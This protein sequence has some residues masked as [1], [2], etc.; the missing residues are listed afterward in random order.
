ME[1]S[2]WQNVEEDLNLCFS[3]MEVREIQQ[4]TT[5]EILAVENWKG[6]CRNVQAVAK[7]K[8]DQVSWLV[9]YGI[10]AECGKAML[11]YKATYPCNQQLLIYK[12][13]ATGGIV[14]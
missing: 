4:V 2:R 1:V 12:L 5:Q 6:L 7:K 9:A 14:T 8:N 10:V 3:P 11:V 13:N